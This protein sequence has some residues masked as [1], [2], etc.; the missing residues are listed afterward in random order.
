MTDRGPGLAGSEPETC[1]DRAAIG[2][3][4]LV[5]AYHKPGSLDE[6]L[7][8]LSLP[9]CVVNVEADP[10]V[11]LVARRHG[12]DVIDLSDNPG[13]G[14]AV[15]VGIRSVTTE[16]VLVLNDDVLISTEAVCRLLTRLAAGADVCGPRLLT[17]A[18]EVEGSVIGLPDPIQM[19]LTVLLPDRPVPGLGWLPVSKW[20][21]SEA[22]VTEGSVAVPGLCAAALAVRTGLL[23]RIPM[24]EQYFMY[25]EEAEWFWRLRRIGARV[26][27]A[28]DTT[29]VHAGG[30][31]D[32]RPAKAAL[33]AR[34]A[35]RCVRRT[36][37]RPGALVVWPA[38]VL[39]ALRLLVIDAMRRARGTV[40][41]DRTAARAAGLRAA[42]LAIAEL[43]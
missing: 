7:G 21:S 3:T 9:A 18:G 8:R 42:A 27:L 41:P 32:V 14:Y 37:G 31:G 17:P 30:R 16:A 34:N 38:V 33:L 23:R 11:A 13:Y 1:L 35:V 43:W 24:P 39:G 4:T 5:I 2:V 19:M 15:N 26:E 36:H 29:A 20:A 12:A 40:G 6:L 25:W 28:A 10:E 22:S